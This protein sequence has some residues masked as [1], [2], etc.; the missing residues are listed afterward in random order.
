MKTIKILVLAML[1][2]SILN[3]QNCL[4]ALKKGTKLTYEIS[5]YPLTIQVLGANQYKMKQ[6]EKDEIIEKHKNDILS[7]KIQP[8]KS[9]FATE[10][11]N[12]SDFNGATEYEASYDVSG[13][14][15]KSWIACRND[16][17]FMYRTKGIQYTIWNGDT[18]GFGLLGTEIIPVNIKVDDNI[19][20]YSD[21]GQ[22]F[23][24][25]EAVQVQRSFNVYDDYNPFS[26]YQTSYYGK[27]T[28]NEKWTY[29]SEYYKIFQGGKVL[30]E[31]TFSIG[32]KDYKGYF[33]G[34]ET[35][36]KFGT[37][38]KIEVEEKNYFNDVNYK[39]NHKITK[40]I[41]RSFDKGGKKSKAMID[42]ISG[43]NEFGYVVGY[44]EDLFVPEIGIVKTVTYDNYGNIT[45]ITNLVTLQ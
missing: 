2:T 13:T 8:T 16:S 1:A 33:I 23:P 40:D 7:G 27:V 31:E 43:A 3:A 28:S 14:I 24:K 6:K 22:S 12:V 17:I 29:T 36:T 19:P 39:L 4:I 20:G 41:Q 15:Y 5:N 38:I 9:T 18:L 34:T 44:K 42:E 30:A 10:I 11:T 45:S 32:G 37:D 25:T 26:R 21:I 35:W